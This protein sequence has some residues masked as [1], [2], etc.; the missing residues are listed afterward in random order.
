LRPRQRG[1]ELVELTIALQECRR[2]LDG[3]TMTGAG[4]FELSHPGEV[5]DRQHDRDQ[6]QE[7]H[8]QGIP[9]G[10]AKRII[11]MRVLARK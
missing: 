6:A 2:N 8:R 5:E 3:L 10:I 11:T 9:R 7:R 4:S 1:A